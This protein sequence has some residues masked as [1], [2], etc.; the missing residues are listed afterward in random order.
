MVAFYGNKCHYSC[1]G[2][3]NI[4]TEHESHSLCST[5]FIPNSV[6]ISFCIFWG[7]QICLVLQLLL[8]LNMVRDWVSIFFGTVVHVSL[9]YFV[10]FVCGRTFSI[11]LQPAFPPKIYNFFVCFIKRSTKTIALTKLLT[12][13]YYLVRLKLWFWLGRFWFKAQLNGTTG[14]LWNVIKLFS[15]VSSVEE[16]DEIILRLVVLVFFAAFSEISFR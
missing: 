11:P 16:I 1:S 8:R 4:K 9:I 12:L 6:I 3:K 5:A 10:L 14:W 15:F 2:T 7:H 13:F